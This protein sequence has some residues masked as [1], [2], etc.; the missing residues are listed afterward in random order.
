MAVLL[1]K[2]S[3]MLR[4]VLYWTL[5]L[6]FCLSLIVLDFQATPA[7]D[8]EKGIHTDQIISN[9]RRIGPFKLN[10]KEFTVI[11]NLMK[12]QG[13]SNSFDETVES[14]SI[15]DRKGEVHYQKLFDVASGNGG[16]AE[17]IGIWAYALENCDRK[18][19]HYESG[20]LKEST[21]KGQGGVGLIIYYGVTPSAPCSGVSCQV[22]ALKEE[23]LV[24]L[25][26]PLTVYGEIY[27]LSHGSNQNARVLFDGDTM[28][29]GVWT[30]WFTVIVEVKVFDRLKVEP[31]HHNLTFNYDAF[32]VKV[33]RRASEKETFVR[34]FDYPETS[35]IPRHVIIKKDTKVEFL[36]AY[37]RASI[38]SGSTESS[39]STDAMPWLMVRIDDNEGFVRDAEDLLALGIHPAG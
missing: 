3:M 19:F 12:Y 37:T 23:R 9:E 18:V 15:V 2:L 14:F 6:C 32:D 5:F 16:F 28:R 33:K 13:A 30:G 4:S 10:E 20:R 26:S 8:L 34:L 29:F 39:I 35:S 22:F 25:F 31:L 38:Q 24:P 27:E 17:S 36:W 21:S 1:N 11:L 7:G